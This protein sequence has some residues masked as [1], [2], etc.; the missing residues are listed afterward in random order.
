MKEFNY[1]TFEPLETERLIIRPLSN[2]DLFQLHKIRSDESINQFIDREIELDIVQTKEFM[3]KIN[4]LIQNNIC[5]YWAIAFRDQN[6]LIGTI[7]FWNFNFNKEEA[8]IGYE[9]L[10]EYQG[11]GIMQEAIKRVIKF[12]FVTLKLKTISAFVSEKNTKSI[13]LL[14]K[15]H[16]KI[17]S[18]PSFDTGII[19]N[20][21]QMIQFQLQ[22]D[23]YRSNLKNTF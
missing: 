11:K 19:R 4:E 14:N 15:F 8:E 6:T 2:G 21:E 22:E 12:G 5:L 3:N 1:S 9:L 10:P 18:D 7:C 13:A 20:L 16:F 23:Y 17:V